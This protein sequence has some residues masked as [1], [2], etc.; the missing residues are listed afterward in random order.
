[1]QADS[2]STRLADCGGLAKLTG[3]VCYGCKYMLCIP[4]KKAKTVPS[5][6]KV[7]ALS[8]GMQRG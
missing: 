2:F 8:S 7:M 6:A 5:A 1:V 3:Y 4:K